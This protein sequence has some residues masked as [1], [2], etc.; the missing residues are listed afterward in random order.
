M[1]RMKQPFRLLSFEYTPTSPLAWDLLDELFA[2]LGLERNQ[3]RRAKAKDIESRRTA[4]LQIVSTLLITLNMTERH[5]CS[6][7]IKRNSFSKEDF[8]SSLI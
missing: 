2:S 8:V 7:T 6:R 4:L 1:S 3:K 5:Y